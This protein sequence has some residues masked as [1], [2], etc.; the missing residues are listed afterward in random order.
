[1]VDYIK[2][3]YPYTQAELE[4]FEEEQAE[5]EDESDE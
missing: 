2:N 3:G 5:T 1:M 4:K